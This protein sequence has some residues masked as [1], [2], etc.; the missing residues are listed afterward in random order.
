VLEIVKEKY[1]NRIREIE[2]EIEIRRE[3]EAMLVDIE[4]KQSKMQAKALEEFEGVKRSVLETMPES[5]IRGL[6]DKSVRLVAAACVGKGCDKKFCNECLEH[7]VYH[8]HQCQVCK[9]STRGKMIQN[10]VCAQCCNAKGS[11]FLYC[12][13][14]YCGFHCTEHC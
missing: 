12:R 14:E 13:I 9:H 4:T 8:E 6:C 11:T 5:G 7:K 1:K 10:F 2:I 3:Q